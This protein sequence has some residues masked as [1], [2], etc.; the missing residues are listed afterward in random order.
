MGRPLWR[1]RL[2]RQA[3]HADRD[4]G[5]W[6]EHYAPRGV[7]GPIDDLLFPINHGV[8]Y[9]PGYDVL[10]SFVVY[11]A[12][13]LDEAG[14]SDSAEA[15]RERM[16]SFATTAPIAYRQQNGGDYLIPSM[17]LCP[18]LGDPGATGFA[19]HVDAGMSA[20]RTP[21]AASITGVRRS[22]A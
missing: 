9:Y 2:R 22:R 4:A 10:P 20:S 6:P 16:R 5:G 12:D 15:L 7:N 18:E 21:T 13:K 17:Q 3:R 1:R 11:R 14:F 8:L 19:L